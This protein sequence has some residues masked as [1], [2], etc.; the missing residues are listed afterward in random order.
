MA[1]YGTELWMSMIFVPL[2]VKRSTSSLLLFRAKWS[3]AW[4]DYGYFWRSQKKELNTQTSPFHFLMYS[5]MYPYL[6]LV[7]GVGTIWKPWQ[8]YFGLITYYTMMTK[9][10]KCSSISNNNHSPTKYF[11]QW[12]GKYVWKFELPQNLMCYWT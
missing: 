5:L 1:A 6:F 4:Q 11:W 3:S 8:T 9:L 10:I 12:A 2:V 7:C